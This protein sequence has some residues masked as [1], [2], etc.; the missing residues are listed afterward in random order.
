MF[1]SQIISGANI[2]K[3][4]EE[5]FCG[6]GARTKPIGSIGVSIC[7]DEKLIQMNNEFFSG[8][9]PLFVTN[10]PVDKIFIV[11]ESPGLNKEYIKAVIDKR[12]KRRDLAFIWSW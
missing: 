9:K 5:S 3:I 1:N 10:L 4:S 2:L 6:F 7:F 8:R 11:T 12:S